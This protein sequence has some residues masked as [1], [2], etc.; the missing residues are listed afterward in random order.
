MKNSSYARDTNLEIQ[1]NRECSYQNIQLNVDAQEHQVCEDSSRLN[2]VSNSEKQFGD[3]YCQQTHLDDS[4]RQPCEVWSRVMG[5][6]RPTDSYNVGKKAE[7]DDRT[8]FV[9][10]TNN[11]IEI[12]T[13]Q[14]GD[15]ISRAA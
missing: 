4:E 3:V 5:Y 9:E 6:Y 2:S 13:Q 11:E 12:N 1:K 14:C 7:Y 15:C 10:P 8:C